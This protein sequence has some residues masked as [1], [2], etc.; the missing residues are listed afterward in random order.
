MNAPFEIDRF[1]TL[2]T[3]HLTES[4]TD[5]LMADSD[6]M[7]DMFRL[8]S[9]YPKLISPTEPIGWFIYPVKAYHDLS[10]TE[11]AMLPEDMLGI[12]R[13]A[14]ML[15]ANMICLDQDGPTFDGMPA[16]ELYD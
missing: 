6:G 14:D 9:V 3:A 5:L 13:L 2:S 1:L 16:L 15:G 11:R 4:T 8:M 12:F 7:D 10:K